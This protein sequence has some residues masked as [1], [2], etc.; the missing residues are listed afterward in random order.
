MRWK[1]AVATALL[2]IAVLA[3]SADAASQ[4]IGGM[5]WVLALPWRSPSLLNQV[6]MQ[7]CISV[8]VAQPWLEASG[9]KTSALYG[10]PTDD[11]TGAYD[12]V[13]HTGSVQERGGAL[14]FDPAFIVHGERRRR[15]VKIADLG[16]QLSGSRAYVTGR[17]LPARSRSAAPAPRWR[18]AL[19]AHPKW[20]AGQAHGADKA[21]TPVANS[22][23]YALQGQATVL[24]ALSKALERPRC[25]NGHFGGPHNARVRVGVRLGQVTVQMLPNAATG[26]TGTFELTQ[27]PALTTAD[28][29]EAPVAFAATGGATVI[30]RKAER[31]LQLPLAPGTRAP[32]ACHLGF[33]CVPSG[34][35]LTLT[36]GFT[37]TL[38][39]RT[40]TIANLIAAYG[41]GGITLTGTLDGAAVTLGT[42]DRPDPDFL[43][44]VGAA[45]GT[46]VRGDLGRPTANF[47]TTAPS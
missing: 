6:T 2:C 11:A 45:L 39:A 37:L 13:A 12:P 41:P 21:K 47:A 20:L 38:G 17:V 31:S 46:A 28:D 8:V 18:L 44:R 40:T 26:S 35:N 30:A 43:A 10:S 7:N 4:P 3:P 22:F 27:G 25:V 16:L 1:C 14:Q 34:G 29:T 5:R 15:S 36:G 42:D 33:N 9:T 32:L 23:L 24:G 19:I